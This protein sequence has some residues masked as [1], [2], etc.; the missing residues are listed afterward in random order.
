MLEIETDSGFEQPAKGTVS[1]SMAREAID[2]SLE[3]GQPVIIQGTKW[4]AVSGK[5]RQAVTVTDR[6]AGEPGV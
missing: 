5:L 2:L 6:G 3:S 1:K 4:V